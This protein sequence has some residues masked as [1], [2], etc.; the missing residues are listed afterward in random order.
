MP[1][2]VLCCEDVEVEK[3]TKL[4]FSRICSLAGKTNKYENIIKLYYNL[5]RTRSSRP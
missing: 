1:V 3:V 5:V 2:T 4:I